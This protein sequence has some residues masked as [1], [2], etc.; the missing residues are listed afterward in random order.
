MDRHNKSERAI[1]QQH[2]IE[3]SLLQL[4]ETESYA[5]LSVRKICS[6]ASIPRRTFYYYFENKE[7]VLSSLLNRLLLECNLEAMF[8]SEDDPAALERGFI[9]YFQYWHERRKRELC[10][11]VKNGLAQELMSCGLR[12]ANSE[13]FWKKSLGDSTQEAQMIRSVLGVT[14]VF[15]ALFYWCEHDFVQTPE[16]MAKCVTQL[17]T[18]PIHKS[19]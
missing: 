6:N 16:Q 15:Y 5:S 4:L 11:L 8:D 10:V 2:R 17:L 14:C 1:L 9:R 19:Q 12:W 13:E 7:D 18:K 3:G